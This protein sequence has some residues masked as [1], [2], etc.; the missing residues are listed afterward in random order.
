MCGLIKLVVDG[1]I[2]KFFGV[3]IFVLEGV[4]SI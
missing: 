4:D 1:L 3:Y 2:W